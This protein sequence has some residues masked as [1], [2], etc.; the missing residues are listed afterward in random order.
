LFEISLTICTHDVEYFPSFQ[1][2]TGMLYG[3]KEHAM[4]VELKIKSVLS[5]WFVL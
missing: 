2:V 3:R 1:Q 5:H 4:A